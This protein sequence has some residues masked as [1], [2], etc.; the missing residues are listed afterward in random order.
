MTLSEDEKA[1][2]LKF[3]DFTFSKV[4][5]LVKYPM[6]FSP[7][8]ADNAVLVLPLRSGSPEPDW[9]FVRQI[10]RVSE[11]GVSLRLG[12]KRTYGLTVM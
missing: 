1:S 8:E 10:C 2:L 7:G 3:H 5:R 12:T 11:E 4:L 9:A 6:L